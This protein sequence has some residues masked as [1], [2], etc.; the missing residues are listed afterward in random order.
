[1]TKQSLRRGD[2][3][4]TA[5]KLVKLHECARLLEVNGKFYVV[6][7]YANRI[8]QLTAHEAD[9][10]KSFLVAGAMSS[11]MAPRVSQ[12][13]NEWIE[14][15]CKECI[16]KPPLAE[17]PKLSTLILLVSESCNFACTYC[18]GEYGSHTKRME[19]STAIRSVDL[20]L[21][22]GIR[23]IVFFG[24]EP[25]TNFSVIQQ[26]V[27]HIE[28]GGYQ[29]VS[30]RMT[31]NGSLVTDE[32]AEFLARHHFQVSVSMDGNQQAQDL[33]RVYHDSSSTYA[34]VVRGIEL[35]KKHGILTL[36]EVTYSARHSNLKKQLRAALDLFPVVSCACV[37][38]DSQGNHST[39]IISGDRYLE[40]YHTMLDMQEELKAGEQLIGARELYDR[41]CDGNP[42][43]MSKYLC[44][45]IGTRLI[46]C[47]DGQAVPC[48]EM[49]RHPEYMIC[50]M[51]TVGSL[52]NFYELRKKVLDRLSSRN[53]EE[54]WFTG[55]CETCIQHVS[56]ESGK[57][58]YKDEGTFQRCIDSL[59]KRFLRENNG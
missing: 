44:T 29:A 3:M 4:T 51:N 36:L 35:L 11:D 31:T 7:T 59:Y 55:L 24:G 50:N 25:L 12:V 45:G 17:E 43:H 58:R 15:L 9:V 46:V 1:M 42:L 10:L 37:D 48:P 27:N 2:I 22:L 6:A 20:A 18:Y 57:F 5:E 16:V 33:T 34:D 14:E 8:F 53:I 40:F 38:G 39:D 13:E 56:R 54:Q 19:T 30:L 49:T 23:D 41:I 32:I 52:S 28:H 21:K 47:P 26:T